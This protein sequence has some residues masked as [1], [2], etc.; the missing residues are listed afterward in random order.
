MEHL[1]GLVKPYTLKLNRISHVNSF[2]V[3]LILSLFLITE[4]F[5]STGN[6]LKAVTPTVTT[7]YPTSFKSAIANASIVP[8]G[9]VLSHKIL[10][11]SFKVNPT[12]VVAK[13]PHIELSS[14]TVTNAGGKLPQRILE[15]NST[16]NYKLSN[17]Q[18]STS[19]ILRSG[20]PSS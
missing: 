15:A 3:I 13:L 9:T 8:S 2:L 10:S 20:D 14:Y 1:A 5:V 4:G 19:K 17:I 6:A 16:L 12:T 7:V 18:P 11:A